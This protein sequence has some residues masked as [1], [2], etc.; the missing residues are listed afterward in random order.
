[1]LLFTN[2]GNVKLTARPAIDTSAGRDSLFLLVENFPRRLFFPPLFAPAL[3][4]HASIPLRAGL[5]RRCSRCLALSAIAFVSYSCPLSPTPRLLF[6]L[7]IE[8]H[9]EF[10]ALSSRRYCHRCIIFRWKEKQME[11]RRQPHDEYRCKVE[12]ETHARFT[13]LEY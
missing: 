1:M 7:C 4:R 6:M 13:V 3:P 9:L 8:M 5:V 11:W 12:R 2:N 10:D